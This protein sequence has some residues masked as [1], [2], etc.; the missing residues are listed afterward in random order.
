MNLSINYENTECKVI[1]G[2]SFQI[3]LMLL[4]EVFYIILISFDSLVL[5]SVASSHKMDK[6]PR[7]NYDYV[8]KNHNWRLLK[9]VVQIKRQTKV[10]QTGCHR[11][12]Q[13]QTM[14]EWRV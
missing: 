14:L 8:K 9:I 3:K 5:S 2:H 6:D 1:E 7:K 12:R 4:L 10:Q 11:L 13:H